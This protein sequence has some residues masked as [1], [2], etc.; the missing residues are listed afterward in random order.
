MSGCLTSFGVFWGGAALRK[1]KLDPGR[2]GG[3]F[4]AVKSGSRRYFLKTFRTGCD[5][6]YCHENNR[7]NIVPDGSQPK[8]SGVRHNRTL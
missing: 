6:D 7:Q 5:D 8:Y 2:G 4:G 3:D 1:R